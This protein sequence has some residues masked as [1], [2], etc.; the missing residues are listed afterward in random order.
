MLIRVDSDE[1]RCWHEI[2]HATACWHLGGDVDFIPDD[3]ATA[4]A[5]D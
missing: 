3:S 2:G 4:K 1:Y 5:I